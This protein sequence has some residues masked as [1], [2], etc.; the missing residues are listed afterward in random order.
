MVS[1]QILDYYVGKASYPLAVPFSSSQ[2][3][4]SIQISQLAFLIMPITTNDTCLI[5]CEHYIAGDRAYGHGVCAAH[6][7]RI[8]ITAWTAALRKDNSPVN[9][10]ECNQ[11]FS[12]P[13]SQDK[14][15]EEK[16]KE[17]HD[18]GAGEC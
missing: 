14:A 6:Y 1:L 15:T 3:H 16:L 12:G 4:D 13:L 9:C 10:P 5:C 2:I 17:V 18:S 7:H 11:P 8:R